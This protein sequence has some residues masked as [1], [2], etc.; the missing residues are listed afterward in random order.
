MLLPRGKNY[1][2]AGAMDHW[3]LYKKNGGTSV[4]PLKQT[5]SNGKKY[6]SAA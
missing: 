3:R 6:L 5:T 4:Q 1:I 2:E